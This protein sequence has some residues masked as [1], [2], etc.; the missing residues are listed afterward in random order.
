VLTLAKGTY[1]ATPIRIT[2]RNAIVDLLIGG[3]ARIHALT[4]ERWK[5]KVGL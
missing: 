1:L 5:I 4:E 3:L 2:P